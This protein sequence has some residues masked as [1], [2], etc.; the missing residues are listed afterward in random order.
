MWSCSASISPVCSLTSL[1]CLCFILC[2]PHGPG[3][4]NWLQKGAAIPSYTP[5]SLLPSKYCSDLPAWMVIGVWGKQCVY[6]FLLRLLQGQKPTYPVYPFH[7]FNAERVYGCKDHWEKCM[8]KKFPFWLTH[9]GY[10]CAW[11]SEKTYYNSSLQ[12]ICIN[13][14]QCK[15]NFHCQHK[16]FTY[17]PEA[18]FFN[19]CYIHFLIRDCI[20][21]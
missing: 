21:Y 1:L 12:K 20:K 2:H 15:L 4:V 19:H 11:I 3:Q 5:L 17:L 9:K 10:F 7:S 14:F 16:I 18:M 8:R 6:S 13:F